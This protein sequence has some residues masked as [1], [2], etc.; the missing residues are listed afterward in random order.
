MLGS[1]RGLLELSR[2]KSEWTQP[3]AII[4]VE[5]SSA[6]GVVE[7]LSTLPQRNNKLV[8]AVAGAEGALICVLVLLDVLVDALRRGLATRGGRRTAP[9]RDCAGESRS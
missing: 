4:V 8:I 9:F 6:A 5:I 7:H 3:S 2:W 1:G